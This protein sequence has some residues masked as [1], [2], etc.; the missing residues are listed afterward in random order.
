MTARDF[1]EDYADLLD[2]NDELKSFIKLAT[3]TLSR[4]YFIELIH[5]LEKAEIDTITPR[6]EVLKDYCIG[7]AQNYKDTNYSTLTLEEYMK[8]NFNYNLE[9]PLNVV[10]KI[11]KETIENYK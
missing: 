4:P 6:I 8:K 10:N 7:A 9:L 5:I 2:D 3:M 11:I 1:I